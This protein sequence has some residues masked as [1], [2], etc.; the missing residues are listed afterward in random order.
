[1][2]VLIVIIYILEEYFIANNLMT[3]GSIISNNF[4]Q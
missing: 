1:M 2:E 3:D 4:L